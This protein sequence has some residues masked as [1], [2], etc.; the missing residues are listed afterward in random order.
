MEGKTTVRLKQ[1]VSIPG[2]ETLPK[3]VCVCVGGGGGGGG[4]LA[5]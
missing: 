2:V 5:R 4:E 3:N 1:S